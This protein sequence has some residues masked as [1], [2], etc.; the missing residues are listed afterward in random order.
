MNK[1]HKIHI[2]IWLFLSGVAVVAQDFR[3]QQLDTVQL[4][5]ARLYTHT[6]TFQ[7]QEIAKDV[8]TKQQPFLT[9]TLQNTTSLYL[10]E[11]GVG[12]VASVSYRGLNASQTAVFWNGIPINSSFTGQT[13]FNSISVQ[14]IENITIRSGG[15]SVPYGS[16]AIA[17]SIHLQSTNFDRP[18]IG[19]EW[20]T[21]LGSVQTAYSRY[22]YQGRK[23]RFAWNIGGAHFRSENDY[24]YV[25]FGN[26]RNRN[27]AFQNGN[28]AM[29]FRYQPS[30][31]HT[32]TWFSNVYLG[33]RQFS[34]SLIASSDDSYE[35]RNGKAALRWHYQ[36][37]KSTAVT[38]FAYLNELFRFFIDPDSDSF[39]SGEAQTFFA[40]HNY[41]NAL[42]H[43]LKLNVLVDYQDTEANGTSVGQNNRRNLALA[44]AT[45]Y[46]VFK[47]IN[48]QTLLR[49]D[50]NS[51]Y[52]SP[53][54]FSGNLLYTGIPQL[55]FFASVSR[56]YR[57]P[58]IN[59][60]FWRGVGAEGNPNL[61]PEDALQGEVGI[62]Y[63]HADATFKL[64]SFYIDIED[65]IV[66]QPDADGVWSPRNLESVRSRGLE[67]KAT[68]NLNWNKKKLKLHSTATYL[69]TINRE[70]S[71]KV[72]FVPAFRWVT[73]LSLRTQNW[74]WDVQSVYT[75][76]V[77]ITNDESES[78]DGATL[79]TSGLYH[80]FRTG[81][82]TLYQLGGRIQNIFNT[83]YLLSGGRPGPGRQFIIET[84]LK[85]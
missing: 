32:L 53:W 30:D 60:I 80:T 58:T 70:T 29:D 4:S 7:K 79:V 3:N 75:S 33:E 63:R 52:D 57:V 83:P 61:R 64:N 42:H 48:I 1:Y 5:D 23:D 85:F 72:P 50:F 46:T 77:W 2:G 41:T 17:G 81:E 84:T 14:N 24:R 28:V 65:Q 36:K 35:D 26:E 51:L 25:G 76:D 19:H 16:G 47:N 12:G 15:G 74:Q 55:E 6:Q 34:G 66:W 38:T 44:L 20:Q 68:G 43:W 45:D 22:Q 56:N 21:G 39:S 37:G 59:D 73:A 8:Y 31:I 40:S 67:A 69:Q 27:G 11:N 54:L 13:D 18:D 49:K 62:S 71:L 10:R 78:I 9:Q 82:K